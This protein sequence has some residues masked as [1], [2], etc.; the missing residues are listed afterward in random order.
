MKLRTFTA[1]DMPTAMKM[2]REAMGDEAVILSTHTDRANHQVRVTAACEQE[3]AQPR[4]L[5][6]E[7]RES[8]GFAQKRAQAS[9]WLQELEGMLRFHN[10]PASLIRKLTG[11]ASGMEL[12]SMLALQKLASA[13][14][15]ATIE[16]KVLARILE[17]AFAFMPLPP[18]AGGVKLMLVGPPGVGKTVTVARLATQAAMEGRQLSVVTC[19]TKRAG[20][21]EQ[22]AAFTDILGLSLQI[23]ANTS[24]LAALTRKLPASHA[25]LIDTPGCNPY[26]P[27]EMLELKLMLTFPDIEPVLTLPAGLD[28]EEAADIVRSFAMPAIKR[29]MITRLDTARRLGSV[30]T[31]ADAGGLALSHGTDSAR[32]VGDIHPL[33]AQTLAQLL[34]QYKTNH[35]QGDFRP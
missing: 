9:E 16:G 19:D 30:L 17:A 22:L 2:V 26:E 25:V 13:S 10:A 8:I 11:I 12:D 20:G 34:L 28:S 32:V 33:D 29:L 3:G 6:Q 4:P 31:A 7:Y 5:L 24:E 15:K 27:Q 1:P 35:S 23:A 18:L 14:S 21:V